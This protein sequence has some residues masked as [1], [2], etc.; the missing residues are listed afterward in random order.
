MVRYSAFILFLFAG[1]YATAQSNR[2]IVSFKDKNNTPFSLSEPEK[3]LS[4][5]AIAR[6][7][8]TNTPV[9]LEDI[10]VN[11]TYVAQVRAT[12]AFTFFTSRWLN[13]LLVEATPAQIGSIMILPFVSKAEM[14][15]P[16][17]KLIGGRLKNVKQKNTTPA[18]TA[19]T[20]QLQMLGLDQM[21][22]DGYFGAG[23]LVSFFDGGFPGVNAAAP[24]QPIFTDN[25]IKLTQ[26]FVANSGNVYQ[27]DKHGTEVF[28]IV[29]GLKA[30]AF[31]G[32]AYKAS[33]ML[34]VTEDPKSEYRVE[35]YNWLFA[36]EK[37][38][39]AGTDVIHSSLG[40]NTFDDPAMD[41]KTSDLNGKTAIVSKAASMA[42]ARGIIVVVSAGNEGN[43]SWHLV[44]PPADVNGVLAVGAV[45]YGGARVNFSSTGPTADGRIKPDVVAV[46][47]STSVIEPDGTIGTASGTSVAAPLVTSLVSG[48]MEK[49]PSLLP[50]EIIKAVAMSASKSTSPDNF[51][52]YGIPNYIAVKNYLESISATEDIFLYPNPADSSLSLSFKTLPQGDVDLT[53]YD[54]QGKL[55]ANPVQPIDWLNNP[56]LISLE[57]FASGIYLLKVKTSTLSRTFRFVKH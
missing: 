10:P 14:V 32:G 27:Y 26:D 38:D 43:N 3:Y 35:E 16:G 17:K 8:R 48:L 12:G 40:Y 19:S 2:Y 41:Y 53:F 56:V 30:A 31:E 11:A 13:A 21:H 52:G 49:Y 54:A 47:S 20:A 23:V 25:R 7:I 4:D 46:G 55:I 6:R 9:V 29:A 1:L 15:A 5:R 42:L 18:S 51:L 24:F 50:G 28:S 44:T 33:Y 34:F 39:S 36:A 45:T 37:S 57:N 22:T